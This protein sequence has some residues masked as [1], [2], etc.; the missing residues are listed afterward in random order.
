MIENSLKT[1]LTCFLT[2]FFIASRWIWELTS[3]CPCSS[4]LESAL[5]NTDNL[6]VSLD[7]FVFWKSG[8]F[9]RKINPYLKIKVKKIY[10]HRSYGQ[11]KMVVNMFSSV[12]QNLFLGLAQFFPKKYCSLEPQVYCVEL[13]IDI[14]SFSA[15]HNL[16][17]VF[18]FKL[19]H[20]QHFYL[21]M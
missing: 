8:C 5:L 3:F 2:I 19:N 14:T 12:L 6:G 18:I 21:V 13:I 11:I 9:L 1:F 15:L 7:G 10:K 17:W 16:V 4:S 20:L